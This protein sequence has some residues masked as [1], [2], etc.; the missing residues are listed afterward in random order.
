LDEAWLFLEHSLFANKIEEWLKT[1]RKLNVSVIFATQSVEDALNSPIASSLLES[2]PSR[3]FL[4]NDRALEPNIHEKYE[5]LGLND[6]QVNIL[7][8][9]VA[10]RQYYYQSHQGNALFDLNLSALALAFCGSLPPKAQKELRRL[11][12][13]SG[14]AAFLEKYLDLC[15]LKWAIKI[16]KERTYA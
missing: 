6:K 2:C 11:Y 3:I 9:A 5:E 10:K 1:L 7:A 14:K 8:H 16:I 12:R 13:E 15:E 4:P